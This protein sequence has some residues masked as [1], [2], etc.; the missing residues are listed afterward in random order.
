IFFVLLLVPYALF[1]QATSGNLLGTITTDG[2]PLA[3]VSVTVTSPSLQGMRTAIS[4]EA[5]GY[6]LP[7]LPPGDYTAIFEMSGLQSVRK[8]V[9]ADVATTS[10]GYV[11][12]KGTAVSEA[13][14]GTAG[15]APAAESTQ[16]TT[17]FKMDTI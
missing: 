11:E 17:N 1:A 10:R 9:T 16:V 13:M 5:G 2:R 3:G 4:G 8:R 6:N 12:M 15:S 14:T 7:S